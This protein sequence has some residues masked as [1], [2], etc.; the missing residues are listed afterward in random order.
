MLPN[1]AGSFL[2]WK[3]NDDTGGQWWLHN[4]S[5]TR[6]GFALELTLPKD[7]LY[8]SRCG[9]RGNNARWK[10]QQFQH[11][12]QFPNPPCRAQ[13][14]TT[15][16]WSPFCCVPAHWGCGPPKQRPLSFHCMLWEVLHPAAAPGGQPW[17]LLFTGRSTQAFVLR[18]CQ[19]YF[20]WTERTHVPLASLVTEPTAVSADPVAPSSPCLHAGVGGLIHPSPWVILERVTPC[21]Q[22]SRS[23]FRRKSCVFQHVCVHGLVKWLSFVIFPNAS[24]QLSSSHR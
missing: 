1:T 2:V 13:L 24:E 18:Y 5:E 15:Q 14:V 7:Q 11:L 8:S 4:F 3:G 17:T 16:L 22:A 6:L 19:S 10:T 12:Q 9:F 23:L 21:P 20:P